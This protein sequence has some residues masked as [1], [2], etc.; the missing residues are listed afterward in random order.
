MNTC[1]ENHDKSIFSFPPHSEMH[2]YL[3][4]YAIQLTYHSPDLTPDAT[5][6]GMI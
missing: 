6:I 3:E 5:D 2:K 1:S 4:H